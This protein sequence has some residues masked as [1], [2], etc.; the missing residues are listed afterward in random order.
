MRIFDYAKVKDPRYFRDGRLDAHSDHIYYASESDLITGMSEYRESLNGVWKFHYA[1]NYRL[2]V[3]GFEKP[4]YSCS[5]WDDIRVPA[6]IQMEGYDAPHYVNVQYPWEGREDIRPGGIPEHFNPTASYV[7]YFTVPE[8]MRG[9]RI[10]IS[11]QGAESGIAVWLNGAFAGYSVRCSSGR[12]GAGARIRIFTVSPVSTGMYFFIR[13]LMY[14]SAIFEY[15]PFRMRLCQRESLRYAQIHG[16]QE[17][18]ASVL[19]IRAACVWRMRK[20]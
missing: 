3:Q 16:G 20:N 17:E 12:P 11:F 4:D 14:I 9:R 18:P 7:K 2:A 13:C 8:R 6:H 10:F 19:P 1:K 5:D 15:V